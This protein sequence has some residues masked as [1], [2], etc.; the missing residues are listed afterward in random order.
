MDLEQ[1]KKD[2]EVQT[3]KVDELAEKNKEL[4]EEKANLVTSISRINQPIVGTRYNSDE[5]KAIQLFGVTSVAELIKVNTESEKA[6]K[7]VPEHLRAYVRELKERIDVSRMMAQAFRNGSL[8]QGEIEKPVA[9]KN[10][11]DTYYAKQ[12]LAPMLKAFGSTVTGEGDEWVPTALSNQFI[13]EFELEKKVADAHSEIRMTTNPYELPIEK[14]VPEAKTIGEALQATSTNAGT[15][16]LTFSAKKFVQFTRLPEELNEDSAPDIMARTRYNVSEAQRRAREQAILNGDDTATHMDSDI[17]GG[18]ANLA[19]KAFKGHRKL[20]LAASSTVDFGGA[21]VTLPKIDEM[22]ALMGA[23][24]VNPR[25]LILVAGPQGY[26][27][28][29]SLEAVT[30][31]EKFGPQATILSGALAAIRGIPIVVSEYIRETTNATGVYDGITTDQAVLQ[32]INLKRFYIGVRRPIVIRIMM[33]LPDYDRWL[34]ASYTRWDFKGMAQSATER[35]TILGLGI[36][37]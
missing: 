34:M 32:L 8:D 20:A 10:I 21:A 5:Q 6:K 1:L 30:T 37:T 15:D 25:D 7:L 12:M 36:Q 11:F 28:L 4:E 27:Q 22:I 33:D 29:K 19:A 23:F 31:V 17:A 35:S 14:N 26:T 16:K 18:A 24:G 9:V 13:E 2:Y 3:K